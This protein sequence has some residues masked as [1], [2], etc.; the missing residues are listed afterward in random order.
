M[1]GILDGVYTGGCTM[2]GILPSVHGGYT[3][4]VY[5]PPYYSLG[6]PTTPLHCW[7]PYH[8]PGVLRRVMRDEALGSRLRICPGESLS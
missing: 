2:V 1:V 7:S 3:P 5:M 6:T 4:P 8:T